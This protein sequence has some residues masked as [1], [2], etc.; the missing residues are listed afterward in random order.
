MQFMGMNLLIMVYLVQL[1]LA[2][3]ENIKAIK[4]RNEELD[5]LDELE[6]QKREYGHVQE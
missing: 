1:V 6:R 3:C 4:K 5:R 2:F